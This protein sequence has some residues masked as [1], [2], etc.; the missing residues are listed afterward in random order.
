MHSR[1]D[2]E[3]RVK[4]LFPAESLRE[5]DL[6]IARANAFIK[7]DYVEATR[8]LG[9]FQIPVECPTGLDPFGED[10]RRWVKALYTQVSR[11]EGYNPHACELDRNVDPALPLGDFFPYS[12]RKADFI[13]SYL[14]GVGF[15]LRSLALP[16]G[17]RVIE[18]GVGWGHISTALARAGFE[19]TCVDIEPK[20][21]ELT[22]R[23][24]R[25]A[26]AAVSTYLGEFGTDPYAGAIH[27]DGIVFFEAFHHSLDHRAVLAQLRRILRPG[28]RLI[29]CGEPIDPTFPV[30]WGIRPD[31]HSLWA[32]RSFGWMELGFSEDYFLRLMLLSGFSVEKLIQPDLGLFGL[33]YRC[34][35]HGGDFHLGESL[36]P[37]DE[38]V[39]WAPQSEETYRFSQAASW[40]TLDGAP[41]WR[42]ITVHAA[43]YLALPLTATFYCGLARVEH[44]F[45]PGER[46]EIPLSLL[47]SNRELHIGSETRVPGPIGR[48]PDPK[49]LGIAVERITYHE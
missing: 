23:Q 48:G 6:I 1:R 38:E 7:D 10:Y 26:G 11:M 46:R 28:G 5:L 20:F 17:S 27:A 12:T 19:V 47:S 29:L 33:L 3:D 14:M 18:Y 4:R 30:P 49:S 32:I 9:A 16:A 31:G 44:R 13:G 24:A 40:V 39:T 15:V 25:A 22:D 36:L 42:S 21:L 34:T 37:S 41:E 2:Q 8:V 45:A 43:N 35:L